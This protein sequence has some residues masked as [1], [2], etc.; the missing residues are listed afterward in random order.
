M[1]IAQIHANPEST[2]CISPSVFIY[3]LSCP[4]SGNARY[5]GKSNNP[6]KRFDQHLFEKYRSHKNHWIQSL[7]LN[8]LLPVMEIIDEV[9]EL[10]WE[11]WEM[12][13]IS[14]YK[15]WGF[16]LTNGDLGWTGLGR[17]SDESRIKMRECKVG[18]IPKFYRGS[19]HTPE[20]ILKRKISSAITVKNR[21]TKYPPRLDKRRKIICETLISGIKKE[22]NSITEAHKE[23]GVAR[24]SIG[25]NLSERSSVVGRKYIFSYK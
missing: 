9:P 21:T 11:F 3:S 25:N 6:K 14:L 5:I 19:K 15:S 1:P 16:D 7:K 23:L 18:K 22:F 2:Q 20:T 12:H 24:Q 10:E 4:T 13:Y 17:H 8:G